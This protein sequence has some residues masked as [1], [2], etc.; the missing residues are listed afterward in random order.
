[1]PNSIQGTQNQLFAVFLLLTIFTNFCQQMM[2][3][4][5]TRR[6]LAEAREL[7]SKVY[8]WQTFILSDIVVE[9]PWNSLMAVLV[10]ACWYYPIGLQQN[11][12]DAGQTGERAIL[13]FLFILAFFNFAGTFTSMAVA[14]MSTAESAG[15]ITNLLFSLS[16][17]FCGYVCPHYYPP[18]VLYGHSHADTPHRLQ[19]SGNAS[20]PSWLLDIHVPDL[21]P[22]LPCFWRPLGGPRQYTDPLPRRRA[23]P[24]LGSSVD[25]LLHIS[26]TLYPV[27]GWL[28]PR[29]PRFESRPVRLLH[30]QPDKHLFEERERTVWRSMAESGHRLG[31]R[32]VQ[33]RG[34]CHLLLVGQGA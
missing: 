25:E 11:A 12:I 8:S 2:P 21:A 17:I 30:G 32:C 24:L 9:V 34:D 14:L 33:S 26:G 28:S 15:N 3:H 16:L 7:P 10:F 23:S 20:S 13:M 18:S 31:L 6:E 19:C 1:M 27:G 4:A 29:S 5:I 22:Y